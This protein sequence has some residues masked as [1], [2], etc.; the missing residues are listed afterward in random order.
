MGEIASKYLF[1]LIWLVEVG[2]FPAGEDVV[3]VLEE[4]FVDNL[5]V[6]EE[7]HGWF[8][9]HT[10]LPVELAQVC[11]QGKRLLESTRDG[12]RLLETIRD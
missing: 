11:S 2:D 5:G 3:D 8:V 1:K 6:C 9:L 4:G 7:E 12:K 10:C